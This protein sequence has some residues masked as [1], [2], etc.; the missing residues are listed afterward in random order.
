MDA[1][2]RT[3]SGVIAKATV[4]SDPNN[5]DQQL[6]ILVT[7]WHSVLYA[8]E[9][10]GP[11]KLSEADERRYWADCAKAAEFQTIDPA[12][13]PRTR[14]EVRDL[15]DGATCGVLDGAVV[16]RLHRDLALGELL[17][18]H[19][20]DGGEAVLAHRAHGDLLGTE[21]DGGVRVLEVEP[22]GEFARGLVDGIAH[23]LLVHLGTDVEAGHGYSSWW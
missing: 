17:L 18:E 3:E 13:V 7:G 10:Y 6:W 12:T 2:A 20:A 22:V 19:L 21:L 15:P 5:P 23:L 9:L 1:F 8:Y 4:A 11:G 14:D 16:E